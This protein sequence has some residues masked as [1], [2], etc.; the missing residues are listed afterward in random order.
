[1]LFATLPTSEAGAPQKRDPKSQKLLSKRDP[2]S[3]QITTI[4]FK[5]FIE[6][7]G[8][9]FWLQ[10]RIEE[11]LFWRKGAKV[12]GVWMAAYAFICTC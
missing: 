3:I 12:T 1:M 2:L 8:P 11:I 5:R 9:V 6:V 4:N 10:D 7:V